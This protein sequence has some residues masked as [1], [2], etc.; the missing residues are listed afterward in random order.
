[1][2]SSV[3]VFSPYFLMFGHTSRIALDVEMGVILIEW[4]ESSGQNYAQKLR[5]QIEWAY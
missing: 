4:G 3:S 2:V 1:M 5:A